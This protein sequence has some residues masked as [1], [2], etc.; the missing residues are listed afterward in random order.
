MWEYKHACNGAG[1]RYAKILR[2]SKTIKR[3]TWDEF[4]QLSKVVNLDQCTEGRTN[5]R[6]TGTQGRRYSKV[7]EENEE[8]GLVVSRRV[9]Y[10]EVERKKGER[11]FTRQRINMK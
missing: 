5:G 10:E 2:E 3:S 1:L 4:N 8:H 6:G 11:E 9:V 7:K